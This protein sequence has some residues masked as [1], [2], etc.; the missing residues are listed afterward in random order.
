[1][2]YA[3]KKLIPP[4]LL[5]KYRPFSDPNDS[6]RRMLALNM[7]WFGS[8]KYFDDTKDFIFPGIK[9]DRRLREY[10]LQREN[11]YMQ[12]VLDKTGV[13]CLSAKAE[14]PE[15][16]SKYADHGAGL[17]VELESDH[18]TDPDHGPF[19]VTYSD[20]PKPAWQYGASQ[21]K[22]NA[23]TTAA[24]LQKSTGWRYQIEWRCI[25][26]WARD[27]KPTAQRYYPVKSR[28]LVGI[29]FGW[30]LSEH[31]RRQMIEWTSAGPWTRLIRF[32]QAIP[33]GDRIKI[34]D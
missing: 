24:L 29:I 16:W 10:D 26:T 18:V 9:P 34:Y 27:A 22:R 6:V 25:R 12:D 28:A 14:Q 21:E 8:R 30:K 1:M 20:K 13:F 3:K 32:R 23:L 31:E 7:W 4:K 33:V 17:C 2:G 11:V 15:L 5:F 19:S